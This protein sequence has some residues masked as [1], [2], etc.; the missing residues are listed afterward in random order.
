[1][2]SFVLIPDCV[3]KKNLNTQSGIKRKNP[4]Y[5]A[6]QISI[7]KAG[8]LKEEMIEILVAKAKPLED[9]IL[10]YPRIIWL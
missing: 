7:K 1:M 5:P 4:K 2:E 9:K 8:S 6:S 3:Q 10:Y